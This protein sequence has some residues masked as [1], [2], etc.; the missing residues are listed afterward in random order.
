MPEAIVVPITLTK[1]PKGGYGMRAL[2]DDSRRSPPAAAR[3]P[4]FDLSLRRQVAT[5]AGGKHGYL[6]AKCSDGNFV[7]EPEVEF[8]DG[9]C[10]RGCSPSGAPEGC[11]RPGYA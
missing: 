10:A 1:L 5:T 7:F 4:R 8:D 11:A 9:S 6:L 3:S 2:V